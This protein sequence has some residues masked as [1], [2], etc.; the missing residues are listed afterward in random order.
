MN[1][2]WSIIGLSSL[3]ASVVTVVLGIVRDVLVEK[4]RFKRE[5]EAGYL[6]SQIQLYSRIYYY[7]RR[8]RLGEAIYEIF[9]GWKEGVKE[10]NA[11]FK[12]E[13]SLLDKRVLNK[14]FSIWKS[15]RDYLEETDDKIKKELYD[16]AT[17]DAIELLSIIKEIMNDNLIPK[18]RK[19]VGETVPDLG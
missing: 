3:V 19:I 11:I 18:Y 12:A 16:G 10:M 7:L 5:S 6:Q 9:G 1:D 13:S 8:P 17:E 15:Y 4:S 2:I 14:W